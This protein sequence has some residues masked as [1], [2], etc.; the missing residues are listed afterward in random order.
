MPAGLHKSD[1][2]GGHGG[3]PF[4]VL[5]DDPQP[6][7]AFR[8]R[9]G[10]WSRGPVIGWIAPAIDRAPPP[11]LGDE[12]TFTA[13]KPGYVVGGLE[14]SVD[15]VN[16][17]AYRVVFVAWKDGRVNLTDTYKSDWIGSPALGETKLL[18]GDGVVV[19][20]FGRRGLN[21]DALGVI[22]RP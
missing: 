17:F 2:F 9:M 16:I 19:G 14:V 1:Q 10:R 3:S 5:S 15:N 18:G 20:M 6:V 13:A 4:Y 7:V 22:T 21:N 8:S 11:S 12:E